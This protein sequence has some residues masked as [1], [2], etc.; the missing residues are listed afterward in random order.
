M[1]KQGLFMTLAGG[2]ALVFVVAALV[3]NRVG[4]NET[5]FIITIGMLCG[6]AVLASVL[7]GACSLLGLRAV[8]I[9]EG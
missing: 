7:V 9:R 1:A 6:P 2:V 8:D 3:I 5:A 4:I